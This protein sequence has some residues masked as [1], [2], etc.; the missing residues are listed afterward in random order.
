VKKKVNVEV[1]SAKTLP[2]Q[3]NDGN[4]D[5]KLSQPD[6]KHLADPKRQACILSWPYPVTFWSLWLVATLWFRIESYDQGRAI[7]TTLTKSS[8]LQFWLKLVF[9]P[10]SKQNKEVFF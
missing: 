4:Q 6:P 3:D 8:S 9:K 1:S 5:Y 7:V 10:S 2:F